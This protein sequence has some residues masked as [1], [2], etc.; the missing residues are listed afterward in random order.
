MPTLVTNTLVGVIV[1]Y[2]L[3]VI[4]EAIYDRKLKSPLVQLAFLIAAVLVLRLTT[5]F[6]QS[7]QSFGGIG[8]VPAIAIMFLFVVAGIAARQIF[9]LK[10]AFSW[11]RVLKPVVI[12]PIVLLPLIGSL[13]GSTDVEQFQMISLALLSF[14]NGF[15]WT[16]ILEHS[17]VSRKAS[18]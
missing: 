13:H 14:Q 11:R 15:F 10:G 12:S 7:R 17:N 18:S 6:P 1:I 4:V 8:I 3:F 9:Y 2:A 5:G 16:T